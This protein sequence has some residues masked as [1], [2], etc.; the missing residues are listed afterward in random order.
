MTHCVTGALGSGFVASRPGEVFQFREETR[1]PLLRTVGVGD[2]DE[3]KVDVHRQPWQVEMEEVECGATTKRKL[4]PEASVD[5]R[6]QLGKSEDRLEWTGAEA[7][8]LGDPGEVAAV[9]VTTHPGWPS[10]GSR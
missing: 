4:I 8:A 5:T 7:A 10:R 3:V 6:E 2:A 1:A 9:G